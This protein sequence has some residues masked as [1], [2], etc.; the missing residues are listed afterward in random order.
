MGEVGYL[1]WPY[2]FPHPSQNLGHWFTYRTKRAT[3]KEG[4]QQC[5]IM[6]KLPLTCGGRVMPILISHVT[7]TE[8][9]QEQTWVLPCIPFLAL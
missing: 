5:C 7:D 8:L 1:K 9:A 6:A 2:P 4:L 3:P